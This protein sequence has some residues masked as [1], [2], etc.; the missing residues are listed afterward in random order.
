MSAAG[1]VRVRPTG[2]RS[3]PTL[4][5]YQYVV[6]GCNPVTVTCTVWSAPGVASSEPVATGDASDGSEDSAQVTGTASPAATLTRVQSTTPTGVG[7]PLAT[8]WTKTSF[9][10]PDPAAIRAPA[11]R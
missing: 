8:P 7:S 10:R 11:R 4:N 5:P 3:S 2:E 1:N 6:A 9:R